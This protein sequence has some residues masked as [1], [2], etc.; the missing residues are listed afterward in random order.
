M[1]F[2]QL[3]RTLTLL[4]LV[5]TLA[6][7]AHA[8]WPKPRELNQRARIHQGVGAGSLTLGETLRLGYWQRD[9][10]QDVR[11]ARSD[12]HVTFREQAHLQHELNRQSRRI[13]VQKHDAQRGDLDGDLIYSGK[14]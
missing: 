2:K 5:A 4:A 10:R 8:G 6:T 13:W 3:V 1:S 12:G 14:R 9:I 11:Q 7:A